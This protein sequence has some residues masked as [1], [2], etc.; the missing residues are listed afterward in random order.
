MNIWWQTQHKK[1]NKLHRST[2]NLASLQNLVGWGKVLL[3]RK[4]LARTDGCWKEITT[5]NLAKKKK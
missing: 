1:T 3:G 4:L 5:N 2:E